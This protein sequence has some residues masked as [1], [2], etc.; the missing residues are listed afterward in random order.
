MT[1]NHLPINAL[2]VPPSDAQRM[3]RAVHDVKVTLDHAAACADQMEKS[4]T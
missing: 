4:N 1:L 3:A 2:Y